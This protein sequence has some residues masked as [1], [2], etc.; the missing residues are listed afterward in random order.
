MI[1][2]KSIYFHKLRQKKCPEIS[3]YTVQP[4]RDDIDN[5]NIEI[6]LLQK[7]INRQ[8][9]P[10]FDS[11]EKKLKDLEAHKAAINTL[12]KNIEFRVK[13]IDFVEKRL[14]SSIQSHFFT[15]LKRIVLLY[16][17][18]QQESLK[19]N[20]IFDEYRLDDAVRV[21]E[22][23]LLQ[24]TIDRKSRIRQNIFNLTNT[25]M[26]IKMALKNQSTLIDRIDFYFDETNFYLEEATREIE[27]IPGNYTAY[28]DFIIY[29]LLCIIGIL[30]ALTLVKIARSK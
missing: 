3:F 25:L 8:A 12:I 16:R 10:S 23:M 27:K 15:I 30:L 21:N 6:S 17:T 9:L 26:E 5:L 14:V 24:M 20:E 19:V 22:G 13:E 7:K 29:I 11:R 28:K 2:N 1:I 18:M 4:I